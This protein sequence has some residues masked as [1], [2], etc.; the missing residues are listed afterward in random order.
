MLALIVRKDFGQKILLVIILGVIEGLIS[1]CLFDFIFI[2]S[3]V[4]CSDQL[5]WPHQNLAKSNMT[6]VT[7]L[8]F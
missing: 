7:E 1:R 8:F 2:H 5:H 3:L 6:T 4:Q